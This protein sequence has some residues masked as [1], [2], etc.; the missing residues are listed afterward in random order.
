MVTGRQAGVWPEH[1]Y[2]GSQTCWN[3]FRVREALALIALTNQA[4]EGEWLWGWDSLPAAP[5]PVLAMVTAEPLQHSGGIPAPQ[6]TSYVTLTHRPSL[7]LTSLIHRVGI[8]V[9]PMSRVCFRSVS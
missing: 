5:C 1:R 9:V 3:I 4:G 7:C 2:Q 8:A 6:L